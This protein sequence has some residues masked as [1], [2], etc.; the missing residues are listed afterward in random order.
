MSGQHTNG[1]LVVRNLWLVPETHGDRLIGG[2]TDPERD[3]EDYAHFIG[4]A[5]GKRDYHNNEANAR[6]LAAC[7]NALEGLT[8]EQIEQCIAAR[9]SELNDAHALLKEVG[10]ICWDDGISLDLLGRI[11]SFLEGA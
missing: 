3:F 8:T 2:C 9:D 6:R 5:E 7:W 1:R 4:S 10:D 11:R